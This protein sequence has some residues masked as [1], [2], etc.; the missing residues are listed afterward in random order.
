M[1]CGDLA[2]SWPG[3]K[4]KAQRISNLLDAGN[5][6]VLER[7]RDKKVAVS[8]STKPVQSLQD[9]FWEVPRTE[10]KNLLLLHAKRGPGPATLTARGPRGPYNKRSRSVITLARMSCKRPEQPIHSVDFRTFSNSPYWSFLISQ[11]SCH[12]WC[13]MSVQECQ[14][15]AYTRSLSKSILYLYEM[16][17]LCKCSTSQTGLNICAL[18]A[19]SSHTQ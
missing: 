2:R 19:T 3:D 6:L 1:L 12:C 18:Y 15:C 4:A 16:A 10:W 11:E 13:S 17:L 9:P 14:S 5:R 7:E 8:Q